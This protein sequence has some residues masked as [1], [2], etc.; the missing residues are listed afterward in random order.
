MNDRTDKAQSAESYH[1]KQQLKSAMIELALQLELQ[2]GRRFN[3]T[4]GTQE[5]VKVMKFSARSEEPSVKE[6]FERVLKLLSLKQKLFF[7]NQGVDLGVSSQSEETQNPE[8]KGKK[9]IIYRGQV[10]WV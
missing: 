10:K 7:S 5:V 8:H 6:A 1:E 2:E 3:V 4:K 9:K